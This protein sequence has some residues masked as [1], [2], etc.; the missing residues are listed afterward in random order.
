VADLVKAL[1]AVGIE[2]RTF[3]VHRSSLEEIFVDL[4]ERR[5]EEARA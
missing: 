4:V 2:F 1:V 3:D 5:P